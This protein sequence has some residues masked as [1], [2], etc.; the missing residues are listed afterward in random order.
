MKISEQQEE[1]IKTL[2]HSAS[3]LILAALF[4]GC[5]S[6]ET[7]EEDPV[8]ADFEEFEAAA[9]DTVAQEAEIITPPVQT[10]SNKPQPQ[11]NTQTGKQ[12]FSVQ[13]D[14]VDVQRRKKQGSQ[15]PTVSV[16]ASTPKKFYTVEVGAFRLQ[17]NIRRHQD[18]LAKRFQ[19]PVRV[20]FDSTLQLTR[21]CVGTFSTKTLAANFMKKMQ[22]DF[23]KDYPDLWV[24]YWTK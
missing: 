7:V 24:S 3:I 14:T 21:V 11:R 2:F 9:D 23:P 4:F 10:P 6:S 15:S 17:S 5:S 22:K 13:S 20:L 18:Q 1:N 8:T 19:L 12:R 16:K